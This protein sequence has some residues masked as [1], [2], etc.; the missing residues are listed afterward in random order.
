MSSFEKL[1]KSINIT[2]IILFVLLLSVYLLVT[3][4]KMASN[5]PEFLLLIKLN[6]LE[7][8]PKILIV[9]GIILATGTFIRVTLKKIENNLE[10]KGRKQ[11]ILL[12][13]IPY[14]VIV[15]FIVILI[16]LSIIFKNFAT[17]IASLGLIGF[18]ITFALQKPI[19]NFVGWLTI[20]TKRPY[21]IGDRVMIGNVKGDVFDMNIMYTSLS[22]FSYSGDE[23]AG[24]AITVPNEY[25]LTQPITNYTRGSSYIW[26]T[27]ELTI[28][29]NSDWKEASK[30]IEDSATEIIGNVMKENAERWKQRKQKFTILGKEIVDKPIIRL[31]FSENFIKLRCHYIVHARNRGTIRSQIMDRILDKIKTT[32]KVTLA[33]NKTYIP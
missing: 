27:V 15:W 30:I 4:P 33:I 22:E 28:T 5:F 10:K 20:I 2:L 1:K 26:D 11:D 29:Y 14:R 31:E 23:P 25:V 6:I 3:L 18:G 24:R 21:W 16:S 7:N 19:L 9:L 32:K 12:F 8:L 17:L 13:N